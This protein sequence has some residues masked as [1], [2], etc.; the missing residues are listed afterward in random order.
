VKAT[1]HTEVYRR[2]EGELRSHPLRF[3]AITSSA[4]RVGFKKKLPLVLLYAPASILCIVFSFIVYTKF[5]MQSGVSPFG[6][7]NATAMAAMTMASTLIQVSENIILF[8]EFGRYFTLLVIAWYGAGLISEDRRLGAHLL[9]FSR[10]ITRLDYLLGKFLASATFG[11]LALVVGTIVI[12]S[13]AAFASPQWSFVTEEGDV[14]VGA[15]AYSSFWVLVVSTLVLCISSLLPRKTL[16]L[17]AFFAWIM[18]T[19]AVGKVL[20]EVTRDDRYFLIGMLHNFEQLG[21]W[22]FERTAPFAFPPHWSL[23][24]LLGYLAASLAVLVWRLRRMEVV[25]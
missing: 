16:A 11:A 1:T 9:Y 22:I 2:F 7:S 5:S 10:P 21:P 13:T 3:L 14:I 18:L 15:L 23:V 17:V 6:E 4:L 19:E 12:C 20:G 25:A 24:A 8:V